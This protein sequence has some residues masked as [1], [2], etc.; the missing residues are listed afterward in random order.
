MERGQDTLF[1]VVLG[2]LVNSG[3]TLDLHRLSKL[4]K[5]KSLHLLQSNRIIIFALNFPWQGFF[6]LLN[7]LKEWFSCCRLINED[8]TVTGK[9]HYFQSFKKHIL[10]KEVK[11]LKKLTAHGQWKKQQMTKVKT[12]CN[13]WNQLH[14]ILEIRSYG[15][16]PMWRETW[17]V[18][19]TAKTLNSKLCEL[20]PFSSSFKHYY[21]EQFWAL[22]LTIRLLAF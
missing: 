5:S 16:N 6:I 3:E 13:K 14:F 22:I 9:S 12:C 4:I 17:Y 2:S 15:L 18:F 11:Q 19:P 7:S 21:T 1:K 10:E 8:F 20:C